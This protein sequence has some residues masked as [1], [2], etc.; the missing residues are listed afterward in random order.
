MWRVIEAIA[1]VAILSAETARGASSRCAP[2]PSGG[3]AED[4]AKLR[5]P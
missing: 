5:A 4:S 3:K 2:Y 1:A